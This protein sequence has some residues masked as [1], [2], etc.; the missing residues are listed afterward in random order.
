MTIISNT[1]RY[2]FLK[3][4]KTAG[5]SIEKWL[6]GALQEGDKI[7]T[8]PENL[9]LPVGFWDTSN[10]VSHFKVGERIV[11]QFCCHVLGRPIGT[12]LRE[13]MRAAA[14][15]D[16]V[17]EEAWG[18]YR[19]Y[20]VERDPWDRMLSFW[21]W[22]QVRE[23]VE[24]EFDAF[25]DMI[26]QS[27]NSSLVRGYSN[28]LIYTIDGKLAADRVLSFRDLHQDLQKMCDELGLPLSPETLPFQ[29]AGHRTRE[30]SAAGLTA[31][32]VERISRLCQAEIDLFGWDFGK[33]YG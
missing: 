13:H 19:K 4:R 26:E 16:L 2:I 15:K 20:C 24:L 10:E 25:L 12:M 9:P 31:A 22:R 33:E 6:C 23:K 11:K 28:Y 18:T 27:P 14:V 17:G 32:Q 3:T 21:R 1:H 29:K 7:A 5:T 30:D 8:A